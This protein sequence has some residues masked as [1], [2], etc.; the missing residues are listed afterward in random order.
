LLFSAVPCAAFDGYTSKSLHDHHDHHEP[1]K[2]EE[3]EVHRR[4][5]PG[6]RVV[7]KSVLKEADEELERTSAALFWSGLA[8]GLSMGFSIIAAGVLRHSLPQASWT[9]L[10]TKIGYSV[11]FIVVILGR[12]RL[13]VFNHI[14]G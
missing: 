1:E 2:R 5:S 12:L 11:G 10:V 13:C 3:E 6:G 7:Y 4:S 9:P 14:C 8:A